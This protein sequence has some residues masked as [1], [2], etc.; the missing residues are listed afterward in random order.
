[1]A[2]TL[3][4]I[5][6]TLES[7]LTTVTATVTDAVNSTI[8]SVS[9]K[10][11]EAPKEPLAFKYMKQA[12][13][14]FQ[15]PLIANENAFLGDLTVRYVCVRDECFGCVLRDLLLGPGVY[16]CGLLVYRAWGRWLSG[17]GLRYGVWFLK[18]IGNEVWWRGIVMDGCVGSLHGLS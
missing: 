3:D 14:T 9:S 15:P 11:E 1:M 16:L 8:A 12:Q 6:H 13:Q 4:S 7:T 18:T 17:T 5:T 2:T 10:L